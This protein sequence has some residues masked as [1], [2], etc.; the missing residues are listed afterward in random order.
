MNETNVCSKT[1]KV[2]PAEGPVCAGHGAERALNNT[3]GS[4]VLAPRAPRSY[5]S[6]A[7]SMCEPVA[8]L[9]WNVVTGLGADK[10]PG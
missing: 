5:R 4:L 9:G 7:S 2:L 1:G 6:Q 8:Q 3:A 10:L